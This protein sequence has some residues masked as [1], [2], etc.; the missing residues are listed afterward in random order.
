MKYYKVPEQLLNNV[1]S[2]LERTSLPYKDVKAI[3]NDIQKSAVPFVE[4]EE[5][6]EDAE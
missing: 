6:A 4:D 3:I 5:P 2:Y 1:I